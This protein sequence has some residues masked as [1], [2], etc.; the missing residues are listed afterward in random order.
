LLIALSH[1]LI[2]ISS[3]EYKHAVLVYQHIRELAPDYL[4]D[5]PLLK[6]P[7]DNNCIYLRPQHWLYHEHGSVRLATELS[8]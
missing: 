5:N 1:V 7:I 2:V 4:A 8:R 3:A 6:S